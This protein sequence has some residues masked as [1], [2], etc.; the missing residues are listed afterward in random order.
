M[1]VSVSL[2]A[3]RGKV[4]TVDDRELHSIEIDI[5]HAGIFCMDRDVKSCRV[6]TGGR[7]SPRNHLS[8]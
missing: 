4:A 8:E 2:M 5:Q 3:R 6:K 1:S 7:L